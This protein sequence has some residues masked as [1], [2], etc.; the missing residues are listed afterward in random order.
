M[1]YQNSSNA[2]H[3]AGSINVGVNPG[4][5]EQY[6]LYPTISQL[7]TFVDHEDWALEAPAVPS[8]LN[9]PHTPKKSRRALSDLPAN[10]S[11]YQKVTAKRLASPGP[12]PPPPPPAAKEEMEMEMEEKGKKKKKRIAEPREDNTKSFWEMSDLEWEEDKK[13]RAVEQAEEIAERMSIFKAASKASR[14]ANAREYS[15]EYAKEKKKK[16]ANKKK[17]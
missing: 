7:D 17:E 2:P 6:Q 15:K 13:K 12:P 9:V 16:K 14:A 3:L 5:F 10:I 8:E 1:K 4:S 11:S